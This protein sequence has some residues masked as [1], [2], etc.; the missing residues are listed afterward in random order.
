MA[1]TEGLCYHEHLRRYSWLPPSTNIFWNGFMHLVFLV[2]VHS[3]TIFQNLN[4]VFGWVYRITQKLLTMFQMYSNLDSI[5][6]LI[7]LIIWWKRASSLSPK[8]RFQWKSCELTMILAFAIVCSCLKSLI[9]GDV[10]LYLS[11][12]KKARWVF[13]DLDISCI[14]DTKEKYFKYLSSFENEKL[15]LHK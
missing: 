9:E 7:V 12:L 10:E 1:R 5:F 4:K 6:R 15:A 8:E 2:D 14:F 3:I 13:V 11:T